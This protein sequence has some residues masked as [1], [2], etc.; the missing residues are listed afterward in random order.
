M[1]PPAKADGKGK[2][3][4]GGGAD[5]A[6]LKQAED[7]IH[8]LQLIRAYRARGHQIAVLDPLALGAKEHHP[9]LDYK[10][11]GFT[12][13]DLD[14]EIVLG[15]LER[16]QEGE[17]RA[18]GFEKFLDIKY[19]GTKR[20]GLDGGEAL[21]PALEQI[22]KRGGQ[23]GVKEIVIGMPHRG[24]LNVLANRDGQAVS[25]RSS[26]EFQGGSATRT[27]SKARAT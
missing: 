5:A 26:H 14:R 16:G 15:G 21:I 10:T 6:V 3:A 27:T 20:F 8:A 11:H 1:R 7:S 24:R 17:A 2:P 22:I 19:T 13:A 23:L 9:E 18:E 25:A 4:A 12:D